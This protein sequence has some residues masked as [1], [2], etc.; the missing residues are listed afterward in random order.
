MYEDFID[1][2]EFLSALKAEDNEESENKN[3]PII[4]SS[5]FENAVAKVLRGYP[6]IT[7]KTIDAILYVY[8]FHICFLNSKNNFI[9]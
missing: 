9:K 6:D 3:E 8:F 2:A 7:D 5:A 1:D 4:D